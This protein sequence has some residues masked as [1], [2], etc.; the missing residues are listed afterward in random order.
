VCSLC[1]LLAYVEHSIHVCNSLQTVPATTLNTPHHTTPQQSTHE[2]KHSTE[3]H[4]T[5]TNNT[6]NPPTPTHT[7]IQQHSTTHST[8]HSPPSHNPPA[9]PFRLF[10]SAFVFTPHCS[11]DQRLQPLV[12]AVLILCYPLPT[13]NFDQRLQPLVSAVITA[14]YSVLPS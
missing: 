5:P 2:L 9:R 1:L 12:L 14:L 13:C 3:P 6:I 10:M 11:F 7:T 8:T 4:T